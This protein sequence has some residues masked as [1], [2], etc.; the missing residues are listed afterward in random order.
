[1]QRILIEGKW[2]ERISMNET[3]SSD[4]C[5]RKIEEVRDG[6][7]TTENIAFPILNFKKDIIAVMQV[8]AKRKKHNNA[9]VGFYLLDEIII[10]ILS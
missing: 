7:K 9:A 5:F 3:D 4:A 1:M 2:V 10:K 8:E 6:I